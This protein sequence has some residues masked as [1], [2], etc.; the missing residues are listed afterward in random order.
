MH[1]SRITTLF[2]DVGG[3][4]MTNGWDHRSRM[5]VIE[6]FGM[7][8]AVIDARH[9][10]LVETLELGKITLDEYL[11]WVIFFQKR[12]FSR[13]EFKAK[14]YA[15]SLPEQ[16][17]IDFIQNIKKNHNLKIVIIS[18]EGRDLAEYRIKKIHLDQLADTQI[19][20]CFVHARKPDLEIYR[21]AL[22]LSQ[23]EPENIF[24]IDDRGLYIEVA[25]SLGINGVQHQE[26]QK[27]VAAFEALGLY[28]K[29]ALSSKTSGH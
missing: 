26:F 20:S 3:V 12:P 8:Y 2:L 4:I 14:I 17:M 23:T 16:Q 24:Y 29:H 1:K 28:A 25:K 27:T 19:F 6:S 15:E 5:K 22:D 18:N 13:D 10:S 7:D 9:T 11:D 21:L